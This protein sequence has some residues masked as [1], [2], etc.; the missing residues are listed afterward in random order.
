MAIDRLDD[1]RLDP[2]RDLRAH[3][4]LAAQ[5]LFVVE[6]RHVVR[7]L[8][9]LGRFRVRSLLLTETAE[10][11]LEPLLG[12]RAPEAVRYRAPKALISELAGYRVHQGCLALAERGQPCDAEELVRAAAR[13]RGVLLVL[14]GIANPDN[15][16]SIFRN[17]QGLGA[18]A[19]LL[20][21]GGADPL[22]RKC[23]RVSMG[24]SLQVPFARLAAWPEG[25]ESLRGAGFTC[26]A[27]V[28]GDDGAAL[29]ASVLGAPDALTERVAIVL[30][31]E[32]EGLSA[33]A[34]AA[35]DAAVTIPTTPGFDS[36]NVAT[37]AAIL[38]H[39]LG[40]VGPRAEEGGACDS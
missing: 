11:S 27:A 40:R 28:A 30:G 37:A 25:I 6:S 35:C 21:A 8:L 32:G 14:E 36:L 38:L 9:A 31:G 12:R 4:A 16:G 5:G 20:A 7:R 26:W 19:V 3:D 17:A 15:V 33:E 24:A 39:R 18:D 10:R 23:V 13:A 1:P 34:R 22:Y 29:D 2:Y